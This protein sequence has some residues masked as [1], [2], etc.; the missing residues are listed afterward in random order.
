MLL[1]IV[2]PVYRAEKYIKKHLTDLLSHG[3][4]NVQLVIVVCEDGYDRSA[5]ICKELLESMENTVVIVQPEQGLSV[6]RNTGLEAATGEYILFMDSD[7]ILL[8]PGSSEFIERLAKE[9]SDVMVCKFAL[10]QPNGV[11]IW[12]NYSFPQTSDAEEARQA[13]YASLPDSIW[14]VWRYICRREFL[15]QNDLLFTPSLICE[16]VQWTPRMLDAAKSIAF[17]DTPIYGYFYNHSGQLSKRVN[18]KRVQDINKTVASNIAKYAHKPYGCALCYRLIR[19]SLYSIS[20]YCRFNRA[21]RKAIRP[22]IEAC[23][24]SYM[25]SPDKKV[26]LFIKTR[27]FIPLYIWSA[28]LLVAKVIRNSLKRVLG[29]NK[30]DLRSYSDNYKNPVPRQLLRRRQ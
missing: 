9:Q 24:K 7:D 11:D 16:D 22:Y 6:A 23:T 4:K 30:I 21:T 5:E 10:L 2:I 29:A 15:L 12:P 27:T 14:N 13:I 3:F 20:D 8:K 26:R 19:E 25:L 17:F 1:S 28:A 18:P